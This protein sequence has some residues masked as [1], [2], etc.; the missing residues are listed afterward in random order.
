M[1]RRRAAA[2]PARPTGL[3]GAAGWVWLSGGG[4]GLLLSGLLDLP[5]PSRIV[6]A[7]IGATA[8]V[9]GL[10][11][12]LS[13]WRLPPR[14]GYL[15]G[16]G[17]TVAIAVF[18]QLARSVELRSGTLGTFYVVLFVCVVYEQSRRQSLGQLVLMATCA[19]LLQWGAPLTVALLREA[20][21]VLALVTV[22]AV[23]SSL[24][25][26][27]DGL[28]AR[29]ADDAD[30]DPL[31][32]LLN[33]RAFSRQVEGLLRVAEGRVVSLLQIDIDDF[34][35][36][37]DTLGHAAGDA[38][39]VSVAAALGRL[40][41]PDDLLARTGGEEFAVVLVGATSLEAAGRA[42]QLRAAVA[43]Q[44]GPSGPPLTVSVGVATL[45]ASTGAL[46][47]LLREAD[48]ALY[49]AKRAGRD[50]VAVHAGALPGKPRPAAS[51]RLPAQRRRPDGPVEAEG[52]R[53][54]RAS[55]AQE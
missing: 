32:H 3:S 42:E 12:L 24:R 34:K 53:S 50:R 11:L 46:D 9:L 20:I 45:P 31:T 8:A 21:T 55:D 22:L 30:T 54:G 7:G 38:A 5:G 18:A 52:V 29:L 27:I 48:E 51:L 36:V 15:L 35:Q 33:R 43:G 13:V 6:G 2:P 44:P 4:V 25:A 10:L 40:T 14:H 49:A 28:V 16:L 26:R 41:R 47:A 17:G 1:Q 39:L 37:N 19:G 23:V